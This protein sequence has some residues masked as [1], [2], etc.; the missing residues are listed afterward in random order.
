MSTILGALSTNA[1]TM[2]TL[3]NV[4]LEHTLPPVMGFVIESASATASGNLLKFGLTNASATGTAV[5][6]TNAGTG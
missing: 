5:N 2:P 3:P 6:I 1:I 4:E